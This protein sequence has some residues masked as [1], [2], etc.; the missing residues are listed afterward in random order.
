MLVATFGAIW[1]WLFLYPKAMKKVIYKA[2][3]VT[4]VAIRVAT[5]NQSGEYINFNHKRN[6]K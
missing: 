6:R 3:G 2:W 4:H 1:T 5:C